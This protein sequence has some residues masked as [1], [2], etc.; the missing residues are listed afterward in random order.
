MAADR[1]IDGTRKHT[2][3]SIA[4]EG[5]FSLLPLVAVLFGVLDISVAI[6]VKNTMQFAVRQGARYAVTSQT[7]PGMGH[8]LSI[9]TVVRRYS[10]GFLDSMYRDADSLT[11]LTVTYYDPVTL[12]PVTGVGSNSGGNIVV[13]SAT[14]LSWAWLVPLLR[15]S[16]PLRFSVSSADL[17]EATPLAGAPPR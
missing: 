15:N 13:V 11:Q 1:S 8:D 5:A 16:A 7:V 2:R 14:D 17:M 10:M 3:G 9:K 12:A 4:V 6:L